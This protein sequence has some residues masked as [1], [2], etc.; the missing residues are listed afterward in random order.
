[1]IPSNLKILLIENEDSQT[2]KLTSCLEENPNI[3]V[4]TLCF[5]RL[6]LV[7]PEPLPDLIILNMVREEG[8][9]QIPYTQITKLAQNYPVIAVTNDHNEELALEMVKQG[10][11]DAIHW[12][13]LDSRGLQRS[14]NQSIERNKL[15]K[16]LK[17]ALESKNKLISSISHDLRSPFFSLMETTKFLAE[18]L[19]RYPPD[20]LREF[21]MALHNASANTYKMVESLLLWANTQGDRIEY[22]PVDTELYPIVLE[23]LW[24]ATSQAKAKEITLHNNV[25][26]TLMVFADK[27]MT[28]TILRNLV[29]NAIKFTPKGGD[30]WISAKESGS[31]LQITVKDNGVGMNSTTRDNLFKIE[32]K[33]SNK[34]TNGEGGTGLGLIV[35]DEF[36]RKNQGFLKVESTEG[37]GSVFSLFL[38]LGKVPDHS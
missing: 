30:V 20:K 23:S 13:Q 37:K 38:P 25:E 21:I 10:V 3:K 26:Q 22:K 36:A 32:A 28:N 14:I 18:N 11:Q 6:D 7:W 4:E 15:K 17:E 8:L 34:G 9:G 12:D 5:N 27:D 2:P 33:T 29:S 1:L 24:G 31:Q 35:C 16:D 19:E